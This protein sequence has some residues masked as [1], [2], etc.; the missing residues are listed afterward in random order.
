MSHGIPGWLLRVL[1]RIAND[2]DCDPRAEAKGVL[3]KLSVEVAGQNPIHITSSRKTTPPYPTTPQDNYPPPS[4]PPPIPNPTHQ[5]TSPPHAPDA[6]FSRFWS[7]YPRK[8]AKRAALRIWNRLKLTDPTV[9]GI[10][11][12]IERRVRSG[13]WDESRIEFVPHPST[14]LNQRRWEDE[15]PTKHDPYAWMKKGAGNEG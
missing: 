10:I 4:I 12:D 6:G 5:D 7:A 13:E 9:C 2:F 1:E 14:Y 8:V 11:Q 15:T 3:Y